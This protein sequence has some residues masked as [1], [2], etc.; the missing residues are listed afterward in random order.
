MPTYAH[1]CPRM[2]TYAHVCSLF[3]PLSCTVGQD[4]EV[5]SYA[6]VCPRMPT[7]ADVCQRMLSLLSFLMYRRPGQRCRLQKKNWH[8]TR[9]PCS[10]HINR[11]SLSVSPAP[12]L[13][14]AG[15]TSAYVS[16]RQHACLRRSMRRQLLCSLLRGIRQ[17]TSAYVSI[18]QH[19]CQ[20]RSRRRQL[21]C[22]LLR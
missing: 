11:P 4:N 16:I 17:H 3:C 19:A 5:R 21:L 12:F 8:L 6:D 22:S 14:L 15:H 20:R 9:Y 10:P 2:P 13:Y 1:V 18:R 7:Y